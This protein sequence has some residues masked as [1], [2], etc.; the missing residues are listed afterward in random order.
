VRNWMADLKKKGAYGVDE[1]TKARITRLFWSDW[2]DDA[3]TKETIRSVYRRLGYLVDTHT[4]VGLNVYEKYAAATGDPT[5]TVVASTA[6]PFKFNESVAGAVLGEE[7]VRGIDEFTLL[8]MLSAESKM[9]IPPGLK[10]LDKKPVRHES[11]VAREEMKEAIR[12]ILL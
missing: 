3:E 12:R 10:G 2:A 6:S 5:V 7:A 9:E 4:A 8:D 1:L 11:V